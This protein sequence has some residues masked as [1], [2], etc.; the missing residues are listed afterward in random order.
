[1]TAAGTCLARLIGL[2]IFPI[3]IVACFV[4]PSAP[5]QQQPGLEVIEFKGT[6][7]AAREAEVAPR[8]EG[9]LSKIDL[10]A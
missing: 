10:H 2:S 9:L 3:F 7:A 6:V 5:A 4:I 8:L 1:M